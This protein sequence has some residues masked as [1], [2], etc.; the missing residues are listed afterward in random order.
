MLFLPSVWDE[1]WDGVRPLS[2]PS[3]ASL[4][5]R[6]GIREGTLLFARLRLVVA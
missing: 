3:F 5:L 1:V 2:I 4:S 6:L